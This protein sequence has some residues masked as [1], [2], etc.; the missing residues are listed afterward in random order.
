M[1]KPA[2]NFTT[3]E[4]N[5]LVRGL[6]KLDNENHERTRENLLESFYADIR[7]RKIHKNKCNNNIKGDDNEVS[8]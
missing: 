2:H 8:N 6:K 1:V 7:A 5:M 3:N 4:L